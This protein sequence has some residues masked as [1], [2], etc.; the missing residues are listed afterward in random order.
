MAFQLKKLN[1]TSKYSSHYAVKLSNDSSKHRLDRSQVHC[2]ECST[3][4]CTL[5]KFYLRCFLT[6]QKFQIPFVHQFILDGVT[7]LTF[8][9]V[10]LGMFVGKRNSRYH[11]GS[12]VDTQ[13]G[14]GSQWQRNVEQDKEQEGRNL[15]N[16]RGQCVGNGLLQVVK[17]Q[18]AWNNINTQLLL[19]NS[20]KKIMSS[21]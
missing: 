6:R 7:R 16:V 3:R 13:N 15:R 21:F 12:Q 19:V 10:V 5:S 9:D 4:Y 20:C 14:N 11:V 17:D 1:T 2:T 8:H 18:A